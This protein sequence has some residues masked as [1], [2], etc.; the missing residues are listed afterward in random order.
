MVNF[1][2][3]MTA[4]TPLGPFLARKGPQEHLSVGKSGK[5]ADLTAVTPL[6]PKSDRCYR[7][8]PL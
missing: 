5:K 7:H 2:A 4:I 6:G 8:P 3:K 1:S